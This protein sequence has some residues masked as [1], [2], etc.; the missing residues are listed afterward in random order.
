MRATS[1]PLH[2]NQSGTSDQN[3]GSRDSGI[4]K[5]LILCQY[6]P[7]TMTIAGGPWEHLRLQFLQ[8]WSR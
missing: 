7:A 3:Q 6:L 1:P 2:P 8:L 5:Y 4:P